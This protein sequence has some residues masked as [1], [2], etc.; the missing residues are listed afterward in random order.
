[1]EHRYAISETLGHIGLFD[2]L[3]PRKGQA[4]FMQAAR[5]VAL[6]YPSAHFRIVGEFSFSEN[7]SYVHSL[8]KNINYMGLTDR[9]HPTGHRHEMRDWISHMDVIVLASRNRELM[10]TVLIEGALPGC[11]SVGTAVSGV[12]EI[13]DEGRTG[14]IVPP[15][16]PDALAAAMPRTLGR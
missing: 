14:L 9:I 5:R 15:D 1:M 10:P 3:E 13:I 4:V 11:P 8:R 2:V 6:R 12:R 7:L 16:D